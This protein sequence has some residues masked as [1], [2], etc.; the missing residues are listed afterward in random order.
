MPISEGTKPATNV[1]VLPAN[2]SMTV[3]VII[4]TFN[5][6]RFLGDS[7]SSVLAQTRPA[8]QIIVVDDGSTDNPGE[9]VVNLPTVRLVRQENRGLSAARNFGLQ[10]CTTSHVVFLDA[11]DRLLP[12]ALEAGLAHAAS[13]PDCAL[14]YGG[15]HLISEDGKDRGPD[16]LQPVKDNGYLN[17]LQDRNIITVPATVLHRRDYL[18]E[19]GGFDEALRGCG[20][21]DLYLRLARRYCISSY[22]AIVAE[23][24]RHGQN[25]SNNSYMMLREALAVL[26]RHEARIVPSALEREAMRKGRASWRNWYAFA[27]LEG[28]VS[29]RDIRLVAQAILSSPRTIW[30]APRT[31]MRLALPVRARQEISRWRGL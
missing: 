16:C 28:A 24:R 20:D 4:P 12:L 14:V 15:Y 7:V 13:R 23:Y 11:D 17:L 1:P 5:H 31:I 21:Y 25:M 10:W 8:D 30:S 3:A 29:R 9:V 18:I 6:A 27:M 2:T 22:P 26:D 19:E